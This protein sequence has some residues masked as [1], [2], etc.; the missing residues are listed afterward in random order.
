MKA[1][2]LVRCHQHFRLTDEAITFLKRRMVQTNGLNFLTHSGIPHHSNSV[3]RPIGSTREMVNGALTMS[4]ERVLL[5]TRMRMYSS[6]IRRLNLIK[7]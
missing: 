3:A 5:T 1:H 7:L 4:S 6:S 2:A